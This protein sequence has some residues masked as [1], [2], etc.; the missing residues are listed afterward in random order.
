MILPSLTVGL[1]TL[2][3]DEITNHHR[4][5]RS[6]MFI[7]NFKIMKSSFRSEMGVIHLA[8]EE[9]DRITA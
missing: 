6:E 1:L 5:V 3:A 9:L 8:L 2:A 7:A 4:S